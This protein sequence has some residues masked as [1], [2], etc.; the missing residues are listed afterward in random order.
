MT[1]RCLSPPLSYGSRE[2][3]HS[4]GF[5]GRSVV[6]HS[7]ADDFTGQPSGNSGV[8]VGCRVIIAAAD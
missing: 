2:A 3:N 7:M 6:I 5:P 8:K 4:P 1:R